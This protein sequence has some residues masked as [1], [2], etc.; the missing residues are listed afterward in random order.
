M[1]V[2]PTLLIVAASL[3]GSFCAPPQT[4]K[5]LKPRKIELTSPTFNGKWYLQRWTTQYEPYRNEFSQLDTAFLIISPV[6]QMNKTLIK[7]YMR[8]GNDCMSETEAFRLAN[9]GLEFTSESRNPDGMENGRKIF[10]D[11]VQCLGMKKDKILV[12]PQQKEECVPQNTQE[13]IQRK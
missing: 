1:P 5:M 9:N 13:A 7:A 2:Y 3:V 8:M 10:E 6:V 11:Q 12:L 4:C